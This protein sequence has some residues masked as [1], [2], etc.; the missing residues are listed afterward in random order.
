M[1]ARSPQVTGEGFTALFGAPVAQEDHARRAVLAGRDLQQHLRTALAVR[2]YAPGATLDVG[3]GVHTGLVVIG[4][5]EKDPQRL[6]TA[7][8]PTTHLATRLQQLAPPNTLLISHATYHL[9]Q[10]EVQVAAW[11]PS[12]NPEGASPV[13]VY[14]ARDLPNGG[15]GCLYARIV[16][17]VHLWGESGSWRSCTSAW[18][19]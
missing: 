10:T 8:G 9:V 2:A 19:M 15:Q 6:Y 1:R 4:P 12:S 7:L 14:A 13:P 11:E 5:L 18:R 17:R 16:R 3:L